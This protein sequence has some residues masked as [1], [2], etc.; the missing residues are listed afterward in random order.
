MSERNGRPLAGE[1]NGALAKWS[2]GT[3]AVLWRRGVAQSREL[4]ADSTRTTD[5]LIALAFIAAL[6]SPMQSLPRLAS[7][8]LGLSV[9]TRVAEWR[10]VVSVKLL[11]CALALLGYLLLTTFWSSWSGRFLTTLPPRY[12]IRAVVVFCFLVAFADCVRRGQSLDRVGRWFAI[13]GGAAAAFAIAAFWLYPPV[14]GR[15]LGPG[16]I[17]NPLIAAQAF[18]AGCLFATDAMCRCRE[19][20]WRALTAFGAVTM[21]VAVVLTG[22]RTGWLAL[23]MGL[24]ILLLAHRSATPARFTSLALVWGVVIGGLGAALALIEFTNEFLLPRG[25]SFRQVIWTSIFREVADNGLWF[26]RGLLTDDNVIAHGFTFGHPHSLYLSIFFKGGLVGVA[27]LATL[28]VWTACSLVRRVAT[29]DSALALALLAAGVV[30]W[31]LDGHQIIHKV[32]IVWW[33]FWLPAAVAIGLS[34]RAKSGP[35]IASPK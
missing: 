3:V 25:D 13:V 20:V 32:G 14:N 27:L 23:P 33:L 22:S 9:L 16:Q 21:A 34:W 6:L 31:A 17:Q 1:A 8:L 7:Y 24:G 29:V 30:A 15:L 28:L 11:W 26:G 18:T 2:L 10:S 12:I 5:L 35:V 19:P 4:L